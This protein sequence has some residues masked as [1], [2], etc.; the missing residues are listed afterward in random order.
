MKVFAMPAHPLEVIERQLAAYNAK[1]V[2]GL[3]ATY[4]VD[5]E[6]YTLHG[7]RLAK[8][9]EEMRPRFLARFAEPDLNARLISR[10]VM[11]NVVVDFESITRNFPEGRGTLEMLCIYEISNGLI[12]RVSFAS[13]EKRL[14]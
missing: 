8:G 10:T 12:H 7:E 9:H 13:G 4:A 3:L 6:Q 2:E 5:A 14:N 11:G 1:D